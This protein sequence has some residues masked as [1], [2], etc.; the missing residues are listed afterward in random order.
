MSL[1]PTHS[2][3]HCF[4]VFATRSF[5]LKHQ[6]I[7]TNNNNNNDICWKLFCHKIEWSLSQS[8]E[9]DFLHFTMR[10]KSSERTYWNFAVKREKVLCYTPEIDTA[11]W[12]LKRLSFLHFYVTFI[13]LF[14][15]PKYNSEIIRNWSR[16][17][18]TMIHK[19]VMFARIKLVFTFLWLL[20]TQFLQCIRNCHKS[21]SYMLQ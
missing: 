1:Q 20:F 8:T 4:S 9:A 18:V 10:Q 3:T 12:V 19:F 15:A 17:R 7:S 21:N 5:Y 2:L 14:L 16:V 13:F 11:K 6:C